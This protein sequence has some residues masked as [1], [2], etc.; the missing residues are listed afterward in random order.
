MSHEIIGKSV[1]IENAIVDRQ[2]CI[3][4][5]VQPHEDRIYSL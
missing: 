4:D 2:V 3:L 5:E 1:F